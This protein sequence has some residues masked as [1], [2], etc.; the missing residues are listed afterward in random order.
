MSLQRFLS[1]TSSFFFLSLF[2]FRLLYRLRDEAILPKQILLMNPQIDYNTDQ[3][4]IPTRKKSSYIDAWESTPLGKRQRA[5][6]CRQF[7]V[8]VACHGGIKL[9]LQLFPLYSQ[10]DQDVKGK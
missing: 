7:R 6:H 9:A 2:L 8:I 4:E 1:I 3:Q 5:I 10:K